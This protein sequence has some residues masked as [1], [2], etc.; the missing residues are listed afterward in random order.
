M[1][2]VA[3]RL[4][5]LRLEVQRLD[6][7]MDSLG[8]AAKG[9]RE[10]MEGVTQRVRAVH[11]LV[12]NLLQDMT[13]VE[14]LAQPETLE[15]LIRFDEEIIREIIEAS[16]PFKLKLAVGKLSEAGRVK[17]RLALEEATHD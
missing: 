13:S 17:L 5:Q 15:L 10:E 7:E 9:A 3:K 2:R 8:R 14:T 4:V 6:A 11:D 16:D 1:K 12:E